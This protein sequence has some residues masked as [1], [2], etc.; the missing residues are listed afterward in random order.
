[1]HNNIMAA[2]SK[3]RPLML[4]PKRYSPLTL[5]RYSLKYRPRS[6]LFKRRLIAADQASVFMAMMFKHSSLSLGHQ[7]QMMSD[8]NN[9]DLAPQRQEMSVEN[10]SSSLVPQGLKAS[11]Y[12][13]S[14]PMPP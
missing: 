8:H 5:Q 11:D 2:G 14:D 7:C 13:N 4:G 1:M 12:D 6:S 10:V 3:D 9:S